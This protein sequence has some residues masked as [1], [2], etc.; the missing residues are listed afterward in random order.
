MGKFIN[1][2]YED[3]GFMLGYILNGK[4]NNIVN[5]INIKVAAIYSTSEQLS[6]HQKHYLSSYFIQ[7]NKKDLYHIFLDF[8]NIQ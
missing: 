2:I 7:G 8:S 3:D 1:I 6:K 5:K 4:V